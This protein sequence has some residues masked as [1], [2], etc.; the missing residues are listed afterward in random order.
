MKTCSEYKRFDRRI[1]KFWRGERV[2]I[3]N[4]HRNVHERYKD[5]G[6][7]TAIIEHSAQSQPQLLHSYALMI[8]DENNNLVN[9]LSWFDEKNL[10]LVSRD[11]NKGEIILQRNGCYQ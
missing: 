11:R 6:G 5:L 10:V 8:V 4:D 9:T 3:I 7:V 2:K 1:A